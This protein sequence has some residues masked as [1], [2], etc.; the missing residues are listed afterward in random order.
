MTAAA[1]CLIRRKAACLLIVTTNLVEGEAVAL[2]VVG[3]ERQADA[4]RAAGGTAAGCRTQPAEHPD[5][6]QESSDDIYA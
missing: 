2:A 1:A 6:R 5:L 4:I 3:G